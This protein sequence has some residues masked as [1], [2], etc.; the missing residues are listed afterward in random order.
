MTKKKV[1][2][3]LRMA[4]LVVFIAAAVILVYGAILHGI[5]AVSGNEG[6][7]EPSEMSLGNDRELPQVIQETAA[8]VKGKGTAGNYGKYDLSG[9]VD[10]ESEEGAKSAAASA[11]GEWLRSAACDKN[12][13]AIIEMLNA[14]GVEAKGREVDLQAAAAKVIDEWGIADKEILYTGHYY[15]SPGKEYVA[16][17]CLAKQ[18][19][20]TVEQE[21][22]L[23][24]SSIHE[25][26]LYFDDSNR[27]AAFLP[28]PEQAISAYGRQYGVR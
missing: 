2:S 22:E 28:F 25:I 5:T 14:E 1:L 27:V 18:R 19:A 3:A 24:H 15:G 13:P 26:T 17:F 12:A 16:K 20:E 8:A 6:G 23:E 4:A 11:F 21:Y 10:R 7:R 9:N